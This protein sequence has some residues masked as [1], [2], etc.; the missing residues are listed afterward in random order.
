MVCSEKHARLDELLQ[1]L[2]LEEEQVR[3]SFVEKFRVQETVLNQLHADRETCRRELLKLSYERP[4]GK[5]MDDCEEGLRQ[6]RERDKELES[7]ILL[8]WQEIE[9]LR[10]EGL[11]RRIELG[12]KTTRQSCE[13]LVNR[14]KSD[15]VDT[16]RK[17]DD[18]RKAVNQ[19]KSN[20]SVEYS[21][22]FP[23]SAVKGFAFLANGNTQSLCSFRRL[24][25]GGASYLPNRVLP[26]PTGTSRVFH[27]S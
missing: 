20:C 4:F 19:F 21:L 7:D 22:C 24:R 27:P 25:S 6:L 11:L 16:M 15:T 14:L 1:A 9:R 13:W 10:Q 2:R 18:F 5:E 12:E 26:F 17:N 3:G 23:L 8:Q